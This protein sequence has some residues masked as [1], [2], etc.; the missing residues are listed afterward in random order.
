MQKEEW[1]EA[2]GTL[3]PHVSTRAGQE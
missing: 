1:P 3:L 2:C